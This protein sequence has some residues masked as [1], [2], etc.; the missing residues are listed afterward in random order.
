MLMSLMI[1]T[2][3]LITCVLLIFQTVNNATVSYD[4]GN[5]LNSDTC[6]LMM[7]QTVA[8]VSY[9]SDTPLNSDS[10]LNPLQADDVSHCCFC[11]L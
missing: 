10:S 8:T 9:D 5:S 1:Q 7:F 2:V 6:K 4:S 11:Q 3:L